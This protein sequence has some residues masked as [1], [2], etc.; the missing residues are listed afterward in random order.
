MGIYNGE[1]SMQSGPLQE[2]IQEKFN[3]AIIAHDLEAIKAIIEEA[4]KHSI[5]PTDIIN[6]LSFENNKKTALHFL[7]SSK[8]HADEEKIIPIIE[9]LKETAADLSLRENDKAFQNTPL[10]NAIAYKHST[11][12]KVLMDE[13]CVNL[14]DEHKKSN[15]SPLLLAVKTN[16]EELALELYKKGAKLLENKQVVRDG[17]GLSILDYACIMRMNKLLVKVLDDLE[18]K[19]LIIEKNKFFGSPFDY[20]FYDLHPW[21]FQHPLHIEA[22]KHNDRM[23]LFQMDNRRKT[24]LTDLTELRYHTNVS[25][26]QSK[27][28]NISSRFA[29][30]AKVPP[31]PS[32]KFVEHVKKAHTKFCQ[33]YASSFIAS[34][35]DLLKDKENC[36]FYGSFKQIFGDG[37]N[38]NSMLQIYK[39]DI[40]FKYPDMPKAEVD[41]LAI[42]RLQEDPIY[43]NKIIEYYYRHEFEF[44]KIPDKDL[45]KEPETKFIPR[46]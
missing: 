32:I 40:V 17:F 37:K 22:K 4:I 20:Y 11:F 41:Q 33:I 34:L 25:K 31:V 9:Y 26:R 45:D 27:D 44:D 38:F 23:F 24:C 43:K 1:P 3:K 36:R 6:S 14:R 21:D 18:D 15:N 29:E 42:Q 12:A 8:K 2:V 5:L 10:L 35:P 7:T 28:Q 19:N 13:K 30:I 39:S 16:Q 46:I